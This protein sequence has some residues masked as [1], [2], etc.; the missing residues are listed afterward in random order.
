MAEHPTLP[1]PTL[2]QPTLPQLQYL[3]A[4]VDHPTWADAAD[5]L[6]VTPS[7]L[8]QGLAELERRLGRRLFDRD[9]RRRVP[10]ADVGP[11]LDYA[12]TVLAA[13]GDLG[14]WLSATASGAAGRLRVGMIDVAATHHFSG[15]LRAFR[16]DH[17][18]VEFHLTVAPSA[19]LLE[20]V[21]ANRLDLAVLVMP[22]TPP[23]DVTLVPLLDEALA[24]YGPPDVEPA[25]G[26]G[27]WVG[28]PASSHT[29]QLTAAA[30]RAR[31]HD[32]RLV[33]ESHQP[34]V[35]REMVALG[36]GWTVLPVSQAEGG[37]VPLTPVG[38][39]PLL[40]R[41]LAAVRRREA[42]PHP[43]AEQLL[44]GLRDTAAEP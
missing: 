34:E 12:R 4:V 24:V 18:G 16:S 26:W 15:E 3:V 1:Q 17:P 10:A 6:G 20:L 41:R 22:E 42:L 21:R 33:A 39:E 38:D 8:S 2:P 32:Y 13:T 43:S 37:T 7:A 25:T 19:Q 31:G 9:G 35:L 36:L 29:H 14:R 28:F 27:P 11:V 30:L 5:A 44:A 40:H 23:D